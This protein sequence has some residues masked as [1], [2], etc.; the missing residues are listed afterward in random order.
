MAAYESP[1]TG[2]IDSFINPVLYCTV[3][4]CE[5]RTSIMD[6]SNII[7]LGLQLVALEAKVD[8]AL[9]PP[10]DR[11]DVT[12]LHTPHQPAPPRPIRCR[13]GGSSGELSAARHCDAAGFDDVVGESARKHAADL[14]PQS[15]QLVSPSRGMMYPDNCTVRVLYLGL[16]HPSDDESED[17]R[18]DRRLMRKYGLAKRAS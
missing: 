1:L 2:F 11:Q 17:E 14:P 18:E 8:G 7:S 10:G 16:S 6:I 15:A 9:M 12:G 4:Y 13:E 5:L 3:L